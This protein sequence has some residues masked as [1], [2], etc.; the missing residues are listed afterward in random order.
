MSGAPVATVPDLEAN[1]YCGCTRDVQATASDLDHLAPYSFLSQNSCIHYCQSKGYDFA[2]L[3]LNEQCWCGNSPGSYSFSLSCDITQ[4]VCTA[5]EA[6]AC[7]GGANTCKCGGANANTLFRTSQSVACPAVTS[8]SYTYVGCY[9]DDATRVLPIYTQITTSLD[10]CVKICRDSGFP[11][12]SM[13]QGFACFC[14]NQYDS[15]GIADNCDKTCNDGS[16]CGGYYA[17]SVYATGLTASVAPLEEAILYCG[18]TADSDTNRDLDHLSPWGA[19]SQKGCIHYCK[20]LN[21]DFAGLQFQTQCWCGNSAGS[22]GPAASNQC[23]TLDNN[24]DG[25]PDLCI[26][27]ESSGCYFANEAGACGCG[28]ANANTLFRTSTSVSCP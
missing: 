25:I 13:Q 8:E 10:D 3:Q 12:A 18:C 2:G 14:G 28:G 24:N 9:R 15:L 1:L 5:Q 22:F 6:S 16:E 21:Y 11:Y 20:A 4:N 7:Y 26:V 23:D 17:N 19:L 27:L